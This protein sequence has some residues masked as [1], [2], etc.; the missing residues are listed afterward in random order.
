MNQE[1]GQPVAVPPDPTQD[2]TILLARVGEAQ[3]RFESLAA[4]YEA[5]VAENVELRG[6]VALL[7]AEADVATGDRSAT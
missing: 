4:H 6:R 2:R 3:M 5:L 1:N 7:E